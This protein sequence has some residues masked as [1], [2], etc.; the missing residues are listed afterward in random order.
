MKNTINKQRRQFMVGAAGFTFGVA[1]GVPA[2]LLSGQAAAQNSS[3][4]LNNWVTV[5]TDGTVVIMS[6]AAEMGQGS[7]T[8][9]PRIVADEM[10]ADWGKVKIIASPASDKIYGNPG[11]GYTQYTAGSATVT[12]YFNSLRQFGAQV[13]YVLMDNAAQRWNVPLAELSTQPGVVLHA[14]TNRR[15]TYGE[16]A[17]FAKV[18]AEAPQIEVEP[19]ASAEFRLIGKDTPRVDVDGKQNGSAQYSIDVHVPGM[20]Y[21]AILREPKP[22]KLRYQTSTKPSMSGKFWAGSAWAKC[23]SI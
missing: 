21:G 4:R 1:A 23:R 22:W 18:P 3:V 11:R 14:K 6:P 19:V 12:G 10:D 15:M 16:I 7:L 17:A 5:F 8:S 13:R 20:I 2:A 9:L